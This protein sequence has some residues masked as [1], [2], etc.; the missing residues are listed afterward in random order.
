MARRLLTMRSIP[1]VKHSSPIPGPRLPARS[2]CSKFNAESLVYY[3]TNQPVSNNRDFAKFVKGRCKRANSQYAPQRK[4]LTPAN[5]FVAIS[6]SR[7]RP[8]THNMTISERPSGTQRYLVHCTEF[9]YTQSQPSSKYS[10]DAVHFQRAG[11]SR[12]FHEPRF[13]DSAE[14]LCLQTGRVRQHRPMDFVDLLCG[15]LYSVP[16]FDQ[17]CH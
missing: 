5:V 14:A 9:L 8:I 10:Q 1:E 17:A 2:Q 15:L 4:P 3:L 16:D 11:A 12:R 6:A 13:R 7:P